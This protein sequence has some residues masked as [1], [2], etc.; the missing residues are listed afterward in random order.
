MLRANG[1]DRIVLTADRKGRIRSRLYV[2]PS[3]DM[4]PALDFD[5]R[6]KLL[7]IADDAADLL[8]AV[9]GGPLE[10]LDIHYDE[11]V[12]LLPASPEARIAARYKVSKNGRSR[13]FSVQAKG[14]DEG[15]Y[16]LV[17]DGIPRGVVEIGRKGKG[18]I[19]FF[20][21]TKSQ[22]LDFDPR[23]LLVELRST[24]GT[25]A[26]GIMRAKLPAPAAPPPPASSLHV[27]FDVHVVA[28]ESG[29]VQGVD[30]WRLDD[31]DTKWR[32][33]ERIHLSDPYSAG[34]VE[35]VDYVYVKNG[36][37]VS[38]TFSTPIARSAQGDD[39]TFAFE[40]DRPPPA[41]DFKVS[42]FNAAGSSPR[43]SQAL[44]Y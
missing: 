27:A 22:T 21:G 24:A 18:G 43:S 4:A 35:Y 34:G 12:E 20:D 10:P 9:L 42:T 23:G 36:S 3:D 11:T 40:Y 7:A 28:F 31:G 38:A 37:P 13:S 8:Q 26:S 41:A 15:S 6:G 32:K 17:V 5:P 30:L 25:A 1:V 16:D 29:Q 39:I 33:A 2:L 44:H 14:V 19:G